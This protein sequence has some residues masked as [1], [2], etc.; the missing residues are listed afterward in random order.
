[1]S[2]PLS[3]QKLSIM[4]NSKQVLS[5]ITFE[6]S[7]GRIVAVIGPNG[8]GKTS[9]LKA[10]SGIHLGFSAKNSG[11]ILY[12]GEK[13]EKF[14]PAARARHITYLGTDPLAEFSISAYEYV[15]LGR[16]CHGD[17]DSK[18]VDDAM[19]RC[20]LISFRNQDWTSFSR[21]ERQRLAFARAL[22]QSPQVL[23]LDEAL[24]GMDLQHQLSSVELLKQIT[25]HGITSLVVAHD[26]NFLLSF[27]DDALILKQGEILGFGKVEKV[28]TPEIIGE[29]YPSSK[30][31]L[32]RTTNGKLQIQF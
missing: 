6:L 30:I 26:L 11:H 25:H 2:S 9:L 18:K 32:A 5:E 12:S 8:S 22:V 10:V 27:A 31:S 23:V 16:F 17:R 28:I 21:G 29:L 19:E 3:V 24:S 14:T 4:Q 20:G 7:A 13:C 15:E 1:M